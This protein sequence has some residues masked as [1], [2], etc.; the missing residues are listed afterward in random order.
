MAEVGKELVE[1]IFTA[2]SAG[3][4]DALNDLVHPDYQEIG[5]FPVAPGR[6]GF[7]QLLQMWRAA[8]PD[9][10][11]TPGE[12]LVEGDRAA[13]KVVGTGT[14]LGELAGIPATGKKISFSSIDIGEMRDGKAYRHWSSPDMLGLF[15]QLGVIPPLGG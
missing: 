6:E 13:W 7:V 14:H 5:P 12:I 2:I 10:V 3:D 9:F 11:L 1:D 4:F 15:T 8:F